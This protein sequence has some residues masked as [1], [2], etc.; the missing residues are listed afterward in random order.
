MLKAG[1]SLCYGKPLFAPSS[2]VPEYLSC[3][4]TSTFLM[5]LEI[6]PGEEAHRKP[7]RRVSQMVVDGHQRP[8]DDTW[9][10]FLPCTGIFNLVPLS[11]EAGEKQCL[12]KR[13]YQNF[14]QCQKA[15]DCQP[16]R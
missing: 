6:L 13:I 15:L 8:L 3:I 5:F 16:N 10:F 1:W 11:L 2:V 4:F 14:A 12:L 9:C 7:L